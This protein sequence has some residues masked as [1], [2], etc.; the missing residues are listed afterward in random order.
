MS[1]GHEDIESDS[2]YWACNKYPSELNISD[3]TQPRDQYRIPEGIRLIFPNKKDRPCNPPEGHVAVMCD[4]F[5]CGMRLPLYHFLRAILR[6]YNVCL[7]QLSPNFWTQLVETWF[8][9]Q[10][11]SLDY[12]M[13]LYVF[14][15]LFKLIK[16]TKRNMEP[17]E[18]VEDWY[19]LTSRGTYS[20]I[21][22]GHHSYIKHW[23]S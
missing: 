20:M 4:A 5:A 11:V 12:P 6:S 22:T 14:H 21:I 16:C 2:N 17:K 18:G 8:L 13:P 3:F 7:Y 19:Y 15:T 23:S 10:D 1:G 9:W